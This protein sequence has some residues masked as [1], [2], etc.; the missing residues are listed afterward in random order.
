MDTN[1]AKITLS[2]DEIQLIIDALDI[3]DPDTATARIMRDS[4]IARLSREIS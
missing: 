1:K 3:I 2:P 4:I